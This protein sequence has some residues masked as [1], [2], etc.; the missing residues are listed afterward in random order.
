MNL[1]C[2]RFSAL[3]GL[4]QALELLKSMRIL[5]SLR[6]CRITDWSICASWSGRR[7]AY[8][9]RDASRKWTR[10]NPREYIEHVMNEGDDLIKFAAWF[11]ETMFELKQKRLIKLLVKLPTAKSVANKCLQ[12]WLQLEKP[13]LLSRTCV[14]KQP[15]WLLFFDNVSQPPLKPRR[16]SE[17]RVSSPIKCDLRSCFCKC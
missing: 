6:G 7:K 15:K 10:R 2:R 1:K 11:F 4:P 3:D 12:Q 8:L 17:I 14:K 5:K 9:P 13:M 16:R